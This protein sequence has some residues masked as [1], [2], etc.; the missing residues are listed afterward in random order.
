ML[1][2]CSMLA[3]IAVLMALMMLGAGLDA[4]PGAMPGSYQSAETD[5]YC[6]PPALA[7][8]KLEARAH[9]LHVMAYRSGT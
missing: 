9:V 4:R 1:A 6:S 7:L 3:L 2:L 5:H 8:V